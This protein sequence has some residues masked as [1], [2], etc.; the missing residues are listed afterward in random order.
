MNTI[1]RRDFDV[2]FA[3]MNRLMS[4]LWNDQLQDGG[5]PAPQ[6]SLLPLD[7][8]ESEKSVVVRAS[9][10]GFR[11]EDVDVQVHNG[12]LTI[13]AEQKEEQDESGERFLRRERRF[14][15][16]TRS[17]ALP[18]MVDEDACE[19]TLEHGVLTL[20][21]PKSQAAMPRKIK[22]GAGRSEGIAK[23]G[24]NARE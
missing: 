7:I 10:P 6:E 17:V 20:R 23:N 13:K 16:V 22:I 5:V 4:Q 2:P 18:S 14:G 3:T 19:A 12:I 15:A 9:L 8:S 24:K 11:P 1:I 21:I